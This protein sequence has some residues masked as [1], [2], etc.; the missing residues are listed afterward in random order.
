MSNTITKTGKYMYLDDYKHWEPYD[1]K[2]V[3]IP[4]DTKIKPVRRESA[5]L[6]KKQ[7]R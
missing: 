6:D 2:G 5:I 7:K 3:V 4:T 1:G